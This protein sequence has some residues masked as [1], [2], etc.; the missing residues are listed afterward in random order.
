MSAPDPPVMLYP[1]EADNLMS[2]V[3]PELSVRRCATPALLEALV[4]TK[5]DIL[6]VS[7]TAPELT[8][9]ISPVDKSVTVSVPDK[10]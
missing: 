2:I 5:P 4:A 1:P 7:S 8:I 10:I 3:T 6:E 9:K